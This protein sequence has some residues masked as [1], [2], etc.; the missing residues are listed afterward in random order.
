MASGML[1]QWKTQCSC[2]LMDSGGC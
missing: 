1:K 2:R